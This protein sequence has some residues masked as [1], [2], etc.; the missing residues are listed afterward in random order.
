MVNS[1]INKI[2]DGL[3]YLKL[4][5]EWVIFCSCNQIYFL[6][7]P[8]PFLSLI[9]TS[10]VEDVTYHPESSAFK[11]SW[12][13]SSRSYGPALRLAS[14][15]SLGAVRWLSLGVVSAVKSCWAYIRTLFFIL[16]RLYSASPGASIANRPRPWDTGLAP[17]KC[18]SNK[19][20]R[21]RIPKEKMSA[22]TASSGVYWQAWRS[23]SGAFHGNDIGNL[24]CWE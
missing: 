11:N 13:L 7:Y 8:S 16:E 23:F 1:L 5:I 6:D 19:S 18:V 10:V 17:E 9:S 3:L 2:V 24:I 12:M 21:Q 4:N 22:S 14:E 15:K 20:Q